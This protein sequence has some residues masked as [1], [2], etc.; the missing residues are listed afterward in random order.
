MDPALP[1]LAEWKAERAAVLT[2]S[3]VR[4][5]VA[6]TEVGRLGAV[7]DDEEVAAGLAKQPRDLDLPPWQKGRYGTAIGRAVHAV[8]QTID[9]DTGA[10]LEEAAAA[11]AAAEGVVGREADVRRLAA[12]ALDAPVVR[13]AVAHEHWRETYVAA[14]VG[15]RTLEG[16]VD[17]LFR[18]DDGLV[19]VDYKTAGSR[20]DLDRRVDGYRSQGGA[21][22]LAVEQA[23][24]ERVT[25]VVFVFLTAS[26]AVEHALPDVRVAVEDAAAALTSIGVAG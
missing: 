4:R 19:V 18:T 8:L 9:L 26:G 11:Q 12:A 14:P 16:Y 24:G 2:A 6:A 23:T 25:E 7:E 20:A 17:L 13:R 22:A 10:G 21:Y 5:T 3:A 1:P 15:G